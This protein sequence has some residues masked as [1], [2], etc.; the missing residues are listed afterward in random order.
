MSLLTAIGD[1][2]PK[3]STFSPF[4]VEQ[5]LRLDLEM[6]GKRRS[7]YFVWSVIIPLLMIVMMSWSVFFVK[8]HH[9]GAQLTM[10]ATSMLTLIAYRFAI[11]SVLPPVPYMT[12]MDIFITGSTIFVFLALVEAVIT[13]TLADNE[14]NALAERMDTV[15]KT[16]FPPAFAVF[17][18]ISFLIL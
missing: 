16:V 13:G 18:L 3:V 10:A 9:L 14:H 4:G 6:S 11:S 12:R 5:L 7:S 2:I 1:V 8:P 17:A 15:A